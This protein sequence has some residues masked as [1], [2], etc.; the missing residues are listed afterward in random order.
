MIINDLYNNNKTAVAENTLNE[1]SDTPENG[2]GSEDY[3]TLL[4]NLAYRYW[5]G[6][7]S[8][9]A[10][11]KLSLLG[12]RPELGDDYTAVVLYKIGGKDHRQ[13][14]ID[15]FGGQEEIDESMAGKVVFS[16]TGANGA[17]YEIIQ[18]SPTDF[19]IH[20]NGKH[21]DTYGSLQRAM[22]VL[23]NE[24]QG[25][26]QGM[27]EGSGPVTHRIG[28]TVTDPNHPMVSKRKEP[29][30]KSVRV[31]QNVPDREA[32]INQAIAHH[33]RK[34][35]R[36][37]DHH[38]I[39]TVDD[40]PIAEVSLGDYRK[41]AAVNKAVAQANRFFGRDDAAKVAAAD[42][43]IAKRE[44]GL[45]RADARVKPY[46]PPQQDAE[47]Q[48][49]DLTAK[50]PNIDDL[51]AAAERNRD[52]YYDRAEGNAYYAGREAEQNYQKL[53][54]IQRVIQGLN[55][56]QV[57]LKKNYLYEGLDRDSLATVKLWES[58]GR[59]IVEA[60]LTAN[61]IGQ[62]FAAAEQGAT[63]AGGNRTMIGKGKDAATRVNKAWEDLKTKIQDSGP[64][65]NFDQKVSDVLG[66][67]GMGSADPQFKGQVSSWVQKYRDFATK[68]PMM[69]GA[70]Y[71][72]L[73]AALSLSGAG[74]AGAAV[75]G[76]LKMADQLIQGKR[77]SSAAYSGAKTG[78]MAYGAAKLAQHFG[79]GQQ[80]SGGGAAGNPDMTNITGTMDSQAHRA[81][82]QAIQADPALAHNSSALADIYSDTIQALNPNIDLDYIRNTAEI[83]GTKL[84]AKGVQESVSRE[85]SDA[86][87]YFLFSAA[88]QLNEGIWDSIKG[89]ASKYADKAADWAT[90][91]GT[92][93]TTKVTADKLKN[94]WTKARSPTNSDTVYQV[95]TKAGVAPQVLDTVY[96]S[97]NIPAPGQ[98]T[99]AATPGGAKT[100]AAGNFGTGVG[101]GVGKQTTATPT[102]KPTSAP[103]ADAPVANFGTG[104]G[105]GVGKQL[106]GTPTVT[107]GGGIKKPAGAAEPVAEPVAD[108]TPEPV[109]EP[110]PEPA[111]SNGI[112]FDLMGRPYKSTPA[113]ATPE[114][115]PEPEPVAEPVAQPIKA[116]K[117]AA[118]VAAPP[119]FNA[120][121]IGSLTATPGAVVP[122]PAVKA[123]PD[124]SKS[125]TGYGKTTMNATPASVPG[126]AG[127]MPTNMMPGSAAPAVKAP[128]DNRINKAK[129]DNP[130]IAAQKPYVQ[131]RAGFGAN[132]TQFA[133][134]TPATSAMANLGQGMNNMFKQPAVTPK[135]TAPKTTQ[136]DLAVAESLTWSRNFDPGRSLYRKLKQ[137]R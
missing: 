88:T 12:W 82:Y 7:D 21:I 6:E 52:P 83:V 75:L 2:P 11:R 44:R 101:P 31:T 39:G 106:T 76:L 134:Y 42:Q 22:S 114:P 48:Q 113:A 43:T 40:E 94:A 130:N 93:L 100:P 62:L 15:E 64:V 56:S 27:A 99:T 97:M 95:L 66:K 85:L 8:D 10:E 80:A 46:T 72:T 122:K 19:M 133:K 91:K 120:G 24:V 1:F 51:V 107:M 54:Q 34:G 59:R 126:T 71:A 116:A 4:F 109:A 68:H 127:M 115:T 30:Q 61:Q 63:D 136:R 123:K 103:A 13:Y 117:P 69:Q 50:Y 67:I 58:A 86:D 17:T 111:S 92:N 35:Y 119:G 77:A 29:Y 28:L 137:D 104:V 32:A 98:T 124:Y 81:M 45:A 37:H 128:A 102:M 108:P 70:I 105:P 121:N 84:A 33:R 53:K 5:A 57:A 14:T 125:I 38:Y 55:E 96:K 49:R 90:T 110:T 79:A 47:K 18:S 135:V 131:G 89:T 9:S 73:I 23:K 65:A 132:P 78:A 36:V 129:A 74:L 3:E 16:G 41:K 25:L 60:E 112:K 26:Q 20:A 87:L 118:A